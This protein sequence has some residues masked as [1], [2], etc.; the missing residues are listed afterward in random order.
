MPSWGS[1]Q[2]IKFER[3]M[4]KTD[5]SRSKTARTSPAVRSAAE[6]LVMTG[7]MAIVS[8]L[9]AN[10]VDSV[11]GLPGAQMYP[12][13]DALQQR[14]DA[15]RTYGARHEQGC[16]YM[17]FGYAR[18]TGKPG[19]CSVVPGPGLLNASAALATAMGA[20]APVLCVTGQVPSQFI[21]RGRGHLHELPDQLATIRSLVKWA[22]RIER[23]ADAPAIVNEAFRQMLTGRPGV[24]CIE[25]AWDMM[26]L[27][28]PVRVLPAAQLEHAHPPSA[29]AVDAAAKILVAAKHPM[30]FTGSGAQHAR[31]EV[32][33]L[34]EELDAPVVGFRGGRGIVPNDDPLGFTCADAQR[35]WPSC[36]AAIGIGTRMELP[37]MRWSGMMDLVDRPAAPP[38]VVRIDIDPAEMTRLIPHAAIIADAADGAAALRDAVRKLRGSPPSAAHHAAGRRKHIAAVR[39]ETA[40]EIQKIQP[41][42]SYL[43]VIRD[44]LPRDGLLVE[45]LC[46]V[47]FASA[48]GFPVYEPRTYVSCGFQGT[49][50]F[51]FPTAL[52]VKA[53]HP[54]T[55]VVSII[56]DGGFM[57]GV[58]EMAT[59][60][61]ED[62]ALVTILFN[63]ES[64]GNV[65][66]DQKTRFGNRVI[67][68][69]L[70]N[71]DFQVLAKSFAMHSA[72]VTAPAELRKALKAALAARRPALIEV[73]VP[74]GSESS[75]WEFIG[76]V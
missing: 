8:Q 39:E 21:G 42:L 69:V 60:M 24:V 51:G 49:L 34:A 3:Q 18:S 22:H 36:D 45:E 31:A 43:E 52:G 1:F 10:G 6:P 62:I 44:V 47:G 37:Y 38:H 32:S 75:P 72:R 28:E 26:G 23:P 58:Q 57:F 20:S 11:F 73:V 53:A 27:S 65:M 46:Q 4:S 74:Q 16:A 17:A 13:F 66:R 2:S 30:I 48:Y 7:G 67:G 12:F 14:S 29:V 40:H 56:G 70:Q 33:A 50:G 54:E 61:Q 15:I 19:I 76:R 55:P 41:Q 35:Y 63:N 59:A 71:P 9:V 5:K 64:F 25:M 68:A